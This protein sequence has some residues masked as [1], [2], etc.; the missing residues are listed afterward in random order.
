MKELTVDEMMVERMA[1][2][3]SMMDKEEMRNWSREA[4]A[5]WLH[6][7]K[8]YA[9]EHGILPLPFDVEDVYDTIKA[10][11]ETEKNPE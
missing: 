7:E 10:M 3:L 11:I 5:N 8:L 9:A 1:D 6:D 4:A 2:A